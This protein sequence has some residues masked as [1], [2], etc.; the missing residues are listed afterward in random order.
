[1]NVSFFKN[2]T[3]KQPLDGTLEFIA[4]LMRDDKNLSSFTQSYRQTGNKTFKTEC[5]LFAVA[6]RFEGGKA[7]ENITGLTGLSLVDFDHISPLQVKSPLHLPQGGESQLTGAIP[8]LTSSPLGGTEGDSLSALKAKIIADPHTVMCYTTISGKGLRVIFRYSL[9]Q[10]SSDSAYTAAFFCGNSYYEKLLGIKADMQCK[11]ITRLSGL[12]HDPNVFLR[13]P[14]EAVPFTIDEIVSSAAAYTKQSKEDKQMQRIQTYFDTLIA[15]QLTKDGIVFQSGSHNNYVMRVGYRLAER[16]FSKKVAVRWAVERFGKDY[17]DTE[18]VVNSCFTTQ[19]SSNS[20][21]GERQ[22]SKFAS[23]E[24]IKSFLDGHAELRFNEITR[25]V[26][27]QPNT[28][29]LPSRRE[30]D[31]THPMPSRR[32]GDEDIKYFVQGSAASHSLPSGGPGWVSKWVPL[33]DRIVNSL[34]SNPHCSYTSCN[35][36]IS[37]I[38]IFRSPI[39]V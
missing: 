26:E 25:R 27:T 15:P 1:M 24:D 20:T 21:K 35:S 33:T 14:A 22:N 34:W 29:P 9:Q 16:R 39:W 13:D 23:V 32:E 38:C 37:N 11:N 2:Y 6:C 12:A 19:D 36:L 30:G 18:Q 4:S 10:S 8:S 5:P 28:H 17:P 7:K 3:S 31:E